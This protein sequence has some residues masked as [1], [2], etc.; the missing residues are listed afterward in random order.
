MC[1][2]CVQRGIPC[3]GYQ[4][5][6]ISQIIKAREL[7]RP[8][9]GIHTTRVVPPNASSNVIRDHHDFDNHTQLSWQQSP[10]LV[11]PGNFLA[12]LV[13]CIG[14]V[15]GDTEG[16]RSLEDGQHITNDGLSVPDDV[17]DG[18]LFLPQTISGF[19]SFNPENFYYIQYIHE[20]GAKELLNMDAGASNPLRRLILHRALRSSGVLDG[21]CAVAACHQAQRAGPDERMLFSIPATAFYLKATNWLRH[22]LDPGGDKE[23]SVENSLLTALLLCKYEIIQGSI[24]QWKGHLHGLETLLRSCGGLDAFETDFSRYIKSLCVM[25]IAISEGRVVLTKA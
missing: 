19:P 20:K 3:E 10:E 23:T 12:S 25:S 7:Q 15:D 6:F 11:P 21:L 17:L 4:Q 14:A 2:N 13:E 24:S 1:F 18:F 9:P 8:R 5:P 22:A 16:L